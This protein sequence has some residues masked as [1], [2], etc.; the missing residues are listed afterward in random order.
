L[1]TWHR[2]KHEH[3]F[4]VDLPGVPILEPNTTI[5]GEQQWRWLAEQLE[6]PAEVRNFVSSIQVVAED[7]GWEKWM[8]SPHE[9]ERLFTLIRDSGAEGVL[10]LSGHRHLAELSMMDAVRET[11]TCSNIDVIELGHA[12]ILT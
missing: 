6:V 4:V 10:L 3:R 11:L 2:D 7:H 5:L 12:Q 1:P 8:N 9:R